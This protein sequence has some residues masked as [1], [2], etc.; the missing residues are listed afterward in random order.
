M[1]LSIYINKYIFA[2][3]FSSWFIVCQNIFQSR[4]PFSRSENP[5]RFNRSLFDSIVVS[6]S[7]YIERKDTIL[8]HK[9]KFVQG[10]NVLLENQQ[11]EFYQSIT[12]GTSN[13][14]SILKRFQAVENIIQSI[15]NENW[16]HWY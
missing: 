16:I 7:D 14:N 6:L 4:D 13:K 12:R 9:E 1:F 10:I 11:G 3:Y 8:E 5:K 2:E 15:L